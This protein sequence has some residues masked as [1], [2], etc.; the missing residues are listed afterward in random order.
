[1]TIVSPLFGLSTSNST[2]FFTVFFRFGA[3]YVFFFLRDLLYFFSKEEVKT[4]IQTTAPFLAAL[5]LFLTLTLL[6]L[7]DLDE[8]R[9]VNF[10]VL[11]LGLACSIWTVSDER[12]ILRT[13]SPFSSTPDTKTST[14]PKLDKGSKKR[15]FKPSFSSPM[16]SGLRG[17]HATHGY[18]LA[19]FDNDIPYFNI[20]PDFYRKT[21]NTK[22][23][24]L[25]IKKRTNVLSTILGL[26]FLSYSS[27]SSPY[28]S[29]AYPPYSY[30]APYSSAYSSVYSYSAPY[31]SAYSSQCSLSDPAPASYSACS[32]STT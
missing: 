31:S 30:S 28:S 1:M 11:S 18:P 12:C 2:F 10:S 5:A 23:I 17:A 21:L 22:K 8:W 15:T 32:L 19:I 13:F 25:R 9:R 20:F 6:R 16:F 14:H 4:T 7:K 29:S 27:Y 26:G 3:L 24:G